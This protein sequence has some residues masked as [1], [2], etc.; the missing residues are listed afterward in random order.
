MI[1]LYWTVW[2]I[3]FVVGF[4]SYEPESKPPIVETG[5]LTP[6]DRKIVRSFLLSQGGNQ[7]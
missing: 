7:D 1:V 2:T 6:V 4:F 5:G 3:G